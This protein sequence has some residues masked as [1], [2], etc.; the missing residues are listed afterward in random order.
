MCATTWQK[1]NKFSSFPI[2]T[3]QNC[4]DKQ[5]LCKRDYYEEILLGN[6]QSR[7]CLQ[8]APDSPTLVAKGAGLWST[9]S[10]ELCFGKAL[11]L[12]VVRN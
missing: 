9:D 6:Q 4:A 7:S 3:H 12:L 8:N 11:R 2:A 1:L 10:S 5:Y